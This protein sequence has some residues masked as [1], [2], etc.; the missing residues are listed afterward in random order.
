MSSEVEVVEVVEAPKVERLVT[1]EDGSVVNFGARA[2]VLVH[3]DNE[4]KVITFALSNGKKI[5]WAAPEVEGLT[6]FQV[7]VYLYGL[8]AKVKSS[9]APLKDL[10][11]IEKAI[12]KQIA[13]IDSGVFILK[14]NGREAVAK[15]TNLQKAYALVKSATTG[16]ESWEDVD[17]AE[18][19]TEVIERWEALTVSQRNSI[20]KNA[21]VKL[22]LARLDVV[23][24][25][26]AE[27]I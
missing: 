18:V 6:P 1:L 7:Q 27:L 24:A 11:D 13:S 4:A 14:S 8:A 22:E 20:R 9:L 15:L 10:A 17:A 26:E 12:A 25:K 2:N 23:S 3:S 5:T 16:F 19:I 21:Y